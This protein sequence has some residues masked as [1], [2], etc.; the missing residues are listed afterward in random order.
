MIEVALSL[1]ALYGLLRARA[2]AAA[3]AAAA[4]GARTA[5]HEPAR[6]TARRR[7]RGARARR[8]RPLGVRSRLAQAHHG[9]ALAVVRPGSTAEVAAVVRSLPRARRGHRPPGRQHR[10]RRRLGARRQRYAGAAQR[11]RAWIAIRRVDGGRPD[12]RRRG[13]L[14]A[15]SGAG[16]R[17]PRTGCCSRS[18]WPPRAA[19]P[20]AAPGHQ[21]RRHA[22]AALRQCARAMPRS[23]SRHGRRARSGTDSAGLRKDNTGYDLRDLFIG[24]EGTLGDHHRGHAEAASAARGPMTA[25][26]AMPSLDDAAVVAGAGAGRVSA[27]GS[28]ASRP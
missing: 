2:R 7:R 20:S 16:E 1:R 13:R 27:R 6:R 26:A 14:R 15:A 24:S 9:R 8:R 3:H 25:L 22:G 19:A 11:W 4:G 28:R 17:R 23:R 18:A 12:D 21:R 5:A 10:P